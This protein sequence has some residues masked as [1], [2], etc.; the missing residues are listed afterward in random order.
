MLESCLSSSA[1]TK[2][3]FSNAEPAGLL[4]P[5]GAHM[6]S[7]SVFSVLSMS[8]RLLIWEWGVAL[9]STI[10]AEHTQPIGRTAVNCVPPMMSLLSALN[11]LLVT[12]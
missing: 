9:S 5:E 11:C 10:S 8:G 4:A 7:K 1:T 6:A 12:A 3:D 2:H